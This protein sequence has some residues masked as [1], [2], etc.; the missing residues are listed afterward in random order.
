MM[1]LNHN[2]NIVVTLEIYHNLF[3]FDDNVTKL[4]II[5]ESLEKLEANSELSLHSAITYSKLIIETLKQG[6][7][8]IQS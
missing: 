8:Y 5:A 4:I 7:K 6:V 1:A 2:Q 3:L